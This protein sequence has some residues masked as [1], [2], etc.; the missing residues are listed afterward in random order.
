MR[1]NDGELSMIK[2]TFAE[3]EALLL[4]IRK[5]FLQFELSQTD[6]DIL[7]VFKGKKGLFD[8]VSKTF[9]P[10]LESG[11]PI[12]QLIDLWMTVD[13]KEKTLEEIEIQLDSRQILID[14][15]EQQ[16]KGL[17]EIVAGKEPKYKLL[18]SDLAKRGGKSAKEFYARLTARNMLITHVEMQLSQ[19]DILAGVKD[20]SVEQTKE[21]LFKNSSK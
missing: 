12:H 14:L 5:V 17:S 13:F 6:K 16:L 21:K 11:A 1:F 3:N 7:R 20:E 4:A 19:L 15:L 8:L 10:E 2:N 9:K 18:L